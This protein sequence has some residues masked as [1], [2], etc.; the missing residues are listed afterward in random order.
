MNGMPGGIEQYAD[1]MATHYLTGS[2]APPDLGMT[3]EQ[4]RDMRLRNRPPR[5]IEFHGPLSPEKQAKI[6]IDVEPSD[7]LK[8]QRQMAEYQRPILASTMPERSHTGIGSD[9]ALTGIHVPDLLRVTQRGINRK[10][11]QFFTDQEIGEMEWNAAER[12]AWRDLRAAPGEYPSK[13]A[14][15]GFSWPGMHET[16]EGKTVYL[17]SKTA[18][19]VKDRPSAPTPEPAPKGRKK[20]QRD[21]SETRS[22]VMPGYDPKG[23]KG[24]YTGHEE[25]QSQVQERLSKMSP[26]EAV[27][28]GMFLENMAVQAGRGDRVAIEQSLRSGQRLAG[29]M[30]ESRQRAQEA[31]QHRAGQM[32][33]MMAALE[34][35]RKGSNAPIEA[36]PT[37]T[38]TASKGKGKGKAVQKENTLIR[39]VEKNKGK[40]KRTSSKWQSTAPITYKHSE[41]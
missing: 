18:S 9:A 35:N 29:S 16:E 31:H 4:K 5:P 24:L 39:S 41:E 34:A 7:K 1:S 27:H 25:L 28:A 19:G 40:S 13:Q 20:K 3:K 32:R 30:V 17:L 2:M 12:D 11:G 36:T 22:S 8:L 6:P 15:G 33:E 38:P 37:P 23:E 10:T 26:L 14:R 21:Y